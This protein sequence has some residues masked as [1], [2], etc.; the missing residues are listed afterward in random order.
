M[1]KWI[2]DKENISLRSKSNEQNMQ[3]LTEVLNS[4]TPTERHNQSPLDNVAEM[5]KILTESCKT[6]LF[7]YLKKENKKGDRIFEH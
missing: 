4:L 1:E 7:F 6:L 2:N 5:D 3:M